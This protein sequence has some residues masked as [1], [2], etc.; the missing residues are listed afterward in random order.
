MIPVITDRRVRSISARFPMSP[1]FV[2]TF[3]RHKGLL[4]AAS[5][6][7]GLGW[8]VMHG[9]Q[10]WRELREKHELIRDLEQQNAELEQEIEIRRERIDRLQN[11]DSELDLEIRKLNLLRPGETTFMLPDAEKKKPEQKQAPR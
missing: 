5:M 3:K 10:G 2:H 4:L 6:T 9:A 1:E 11:G 8:A 7:V